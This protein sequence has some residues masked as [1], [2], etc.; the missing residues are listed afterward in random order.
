MK[1]EKM[2][3]A[4][5]GLSTAIKSYCVNIVVEEGVDRGGVSARYF[6]YPVL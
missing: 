2:K 6:G 3:E 5:K 4:S 1:T